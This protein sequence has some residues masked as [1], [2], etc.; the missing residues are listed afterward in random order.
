[1]GSHVAIY[2]ESYSSKMDGDIVEYTIDF[3]NVNGAV[4]FFQSYFPGVDY[5][6]AK[7]YSLRVPRTGRNRMFSGSW[8]F[9]P[10]SAFESSEYEPINEEAEGSAAYA[11]IITLKNSVPNLCQYLAAVESEE[12]E[13]H[14]HISI[15]FKT[16]PR[17]LVVVSCGQGNWNEV[18]A[19]KELLI[20]DMGASSRYTRSQ[21]INLIQSRF[22]QFKEKI[23]SIVISHWDMDHFQAI[24]YL[25]RKQLAQ[26][27]GIVGPSN[28]PPSNVYK[29]MINHLIANN[30][31][32]SLIS[33]T[34]QRNGRSINLN[35]LSVSKTVDV[36]RSVSGGSRNQTGIVLVVKGEEKFVLLTG[37][38]HYEKIFDAI[39][40][41][42]SSQRIIL[43]APH[44]GGNAGSLNVADWRS[45]FSA[46]ECPISYGFNSFNHPHQN[47]SG[48]GLL[49]GS[50]PQTTHGIGDLKFCI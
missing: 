12:Y 4:S 20:Y 42:Y 38:H 15:N 3:Q 22:A 50:V 40:N 32:Y 17:E 14:E 31:K 1:M 11:G 16:S 24:R 8:Y 10:L 29:S 43:V 44:H 5:N 35:L 13:I 37:D 27:A 2:V 39:H 30:V 34:S 28:I 33:P 23:I 25:D 46:I 19:N 48:L 41:N 45:E 26:I 6:D 7:F 47:L 9:L 18:H 21:V 49:Q 36:Y